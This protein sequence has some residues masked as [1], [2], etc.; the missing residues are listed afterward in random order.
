MAKLDS[1][2]FGLAVDMLRELE[3]MGNAGNLNFQ[4][5][6]KFRANS[7]RPSK[8]QR[9]VLLRYL[10]T[11]EKHGDDKVLAGFTAVLTDLIGAALTDAGDVDVAFYESRTCDASARRDAE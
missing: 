10:K 2:G 4:L 7:R 8:Q 1:N 5:F 6:G 3:R 9:N 11:I